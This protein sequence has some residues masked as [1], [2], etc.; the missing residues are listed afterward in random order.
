MPTGLDNYNAYYSDIYKDRWPELKKSLESPPHHVLRRNTFVDDATLEVFWAQTAGPEALGVGTPHPHLPNCFWALEN[1]KLEN[2]A[3][4]ILPYYKM[5]PA[6]IFAARSL[7][8]Q[9]GHVVLDMCAAPGGKT[10]VLCES[11]GEDGRLIANELSAKRRFR[12]MSVIKHYIPADLRRRIDVRGHDG[13]MYGLKMPQHFDRILLDAP[14]SG[15]RGLL[16]KPSELDSWTPKR[17]KNFGIR[18]YS[19]L[20]SA[21]NSL[22]PGGEMVYSTC[23]LSPFENDGVIDKLF[24]KKDGEFS[25]LPI[26]DDWG[27]ATRHG[28]LLLPDRDQAG[29]IF[30]CRLRKNS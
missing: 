2:F 14:C 30:F 9:P 4:D 11:L 23:A 26:A 17:A 10:L 19:L 16:Q 8:V 24:K 6:S 28:R 27:E 12:L 20:A 1:F 21:F 29:P 13:A 25:V 5:D 18:Q 7:D 3:A 22:K 15:D